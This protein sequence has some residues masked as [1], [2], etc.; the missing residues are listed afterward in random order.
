MVKRL[1]IGAIFAG[2]PLAGALQLGGEEL[3]VYVAPYYTYTNYDGSLMKKE[4]WSTALYGYVDYKSEHLFQWGYSYSHINFKSNYSNW[5]Q[6]D[7][8]VKYTNYQ[9]APWF[10]GLGVHFIS[11]PNKDVSEKAAIIVA[12]VGYQIDYDWIAAAEYS[13]G[14]YKYGLATQQ[15]RLHGGKY[16]WTAP[17]KG[18]FVGGGVRWNHSNKKSVPEIGWTQSL[19]KK[20]Y[21]SF[22]YGVNY[23]TPKWSVW[24]RSWIGERVFAVDNGGFVVYNLKERYYTTSTISGIYKINPQLLVGLQFDMAFFREVETDARVKAYSLTATLGYSF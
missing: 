17:G 7:Y 22:D 12:D 11:S 24:I 18:F 13:Y 5:N 3:N 4:G 1:A 21:Y 9:M 8:T 16:F 2:F 10:G 14:D 19:R 15:L 6:N 20:N 23:F